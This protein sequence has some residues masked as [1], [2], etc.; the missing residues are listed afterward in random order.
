MGASVFSR[1]TSPIPRRTLS[2]P[3]E[4]IRQ[5]NIL[6]N[7]ARIK[8]SRA[9]RKSS[10]AWHPQRAGGDKCGQH[11]MLLPGGCSCSFLLSSVSVELCP[12]APKTRVHSS[13]GRAP[14]Y[15][16][17]IAPCSRDQPGQDW[18]GK[19]RLAPWKWC[20]RW[21]AKPVRYTDAN[22][23][24]FVLPAARHSW[25]E[26]DLVLARISARDVIAGPEARS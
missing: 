8:Q 15:K 25:R 10:R 6:P 17:R 2:H 14:L 20:L 22:L 12:F 19:A 3:S 9:G 5:P 4:L 7:D 11:E 23:C 21:T 1:A 24:L 13:R 16:P 18:C 26:P